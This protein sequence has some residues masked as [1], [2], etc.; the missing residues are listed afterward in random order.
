LDY[1]ISC[2]KCGFPISVGHLHLPEQQEAHLTSI[3]LDME[4]PLEFRSDG[5]NTFLEC[6]NPK[7][8]KKNVIVFVGKEWDIVDP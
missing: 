2:K 3:Q 5:I 7:C 8:G 6:P 1:I 4:P